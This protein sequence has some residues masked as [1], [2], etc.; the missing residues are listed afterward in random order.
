MRACACVLAWAG[1]TSLIMAEGKFTPSDFRSI[2]QCNGASRP[3]PRTTDG[4]EEEE[5]EEVCMNGLNRSRGERASE[6]WGFL[7][8]VG[9]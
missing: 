8:V 9:V 6:R 5:E 3:R 7:K 2:I 4:K 1:I